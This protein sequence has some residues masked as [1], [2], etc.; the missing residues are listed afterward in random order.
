M[1]SSALPGLASAWKLLVEKASESV[2]AGVCRVSPNG[3]GCE[4]ISGVTQRG[5][6]PR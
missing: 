6:V 5:T 4:V 1:R 3:S 2:P